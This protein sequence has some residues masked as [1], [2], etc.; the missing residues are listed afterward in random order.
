MRY[1]VRL[2][3]LMASLALFCLMALTFADVVLRS[4]IN[5]PIEAATELVRI[6]M[7]L[8]VFLS[9]PSTSWKG[10]QIAVDLTDGLFKRAGLEA[11]RD[12]L[13]SLVC[14]VALIWPALKI[15]SI[16]TR[17]REYGDQT[18][19]LHIPVYIVT[20]VI[21][22]FVFI[23]VAVLIVRGVLLLTGRLKDITP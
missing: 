11:L 5:M 17:S 9:L 2:P 3:D 14:G 20:W 7:A 4:T 15:V 8:V 10:E 18:E 6:L 13:I 23:T 12:G 1:I 22:L 21:A 19:Y 16:G